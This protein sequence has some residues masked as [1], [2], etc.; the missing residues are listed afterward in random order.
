M[1]RTL[2]RHGERFGATEQ[3]QSGDLSKGPFHIADEGTDT[4]QWELDASL[5][6]PASCDLQDLDA[7]LDK[8]YREPER[9]GLCEDTGREIRFERLDVVP[10][11]RTCEEL[12]AEGT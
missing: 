2:A 1:L 8:L 3:D 12:S 10:W 5:A 9:F 4:M 11:A 6:S 7:A